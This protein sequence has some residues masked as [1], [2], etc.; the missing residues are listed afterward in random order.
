MSPEITLET[1]EAIHDA[2]HTETVNTCEACPFGGC[3]N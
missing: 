2:T 1:V 3:C